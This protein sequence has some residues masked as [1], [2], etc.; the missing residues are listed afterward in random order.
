MQVNVSAYDISDSLK[1]SLFI[2]IY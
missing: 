2:I 1:T